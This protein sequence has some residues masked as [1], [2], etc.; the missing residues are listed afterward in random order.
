M[1]NE[2]R[3]Q[4]LAALAETFGEA[5]DVTPAEAQ[6]LHV[7]LP[8]LRVQPPW[9]P[10]PT[11][12]LVKFEGWPNQRPQ[13]WIDMAVVNP[14]GT[15]PR[16]NTPQLILGETWRQFSFSFPWPVEPVTAIH[17]VLKWLTRFRE[18]S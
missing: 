16:S 15:P 4:I 17:A 7:L 6:P 12:G 8:N 1:D 18:A 10:S 2:E 3:K 13:F 11:R 9:G 14:Q 5:K